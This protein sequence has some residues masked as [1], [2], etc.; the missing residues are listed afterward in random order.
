MKMN[1]L[2]FVALIFMFNSVVVAQQSI[3]GDYA[4]QSDDNKKYSIYV[5]SSYD[6]TQANPL[7]VGLHPFNTNRWD[8]QSWRDTL[9]N[10]AE[11]NQLILACPDG[12]IDGSIDDPID[13]A[14][15]SS[16]IDSMSL[17]FN[18]DESQ[19]YLIGFSRGGSTVYS[20]GLRRV[21][22]FAG[23]I[24]IGAAISGASEIA[25]LTHNATH[26]NWYLIHGSN[27]NVSNRFTPAV[28][29]LTE[30]GACLE[31]NLMQGIGHTID[32]PNR[33]EILRTAFEYVRDINCLSSTE[34]TSTELG[35]KTSPNPSNNQFSI[36]EL[37][38]NARITCYNSNGQTINFVREGNQVLIDVNHSGLIMV[39][40]EQNNQIQ[41]L[42]HYINP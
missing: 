9:I 27:D 42:K 30:A 26:E 16:L 29:Q 25:P 5:P 40:I 20:Y 34:N 38:T 23:F 15:T 7:M 3:D 11:E 13:T 39:Q 8:A 10:F 35:L 28:E 1:K 36:E 4:F 37:D 24:P 41:I 12:G 18:I 14:F 32:F 19:K 22:E 6:E 33:D 21:D 17:W 31:T 2:L